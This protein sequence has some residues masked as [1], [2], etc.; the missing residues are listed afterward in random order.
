MS[1]VANKTFHVP[2]NITNDARTEQNL[3][4]ML[5]GVVL[6]VEPL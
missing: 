4:N 1:G 3:L 5:H 6:P 2:S